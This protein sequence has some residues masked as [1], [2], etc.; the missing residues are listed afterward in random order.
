MH[1]PLLAFVR[2][3]FISKNQYAFLHKQKSVR[4]GDKIGLKCNHM[5]S[6]HKSICYSYGR[7]KGKGYFYLL[8]GVMK[9]VVNNIIYKLQVNNSLNWKSDKKNNLGQNVTGI[10]N[11]SQ[12]IFQSMVCEQKEILEYRQKDGLIRGQFECERTCCVFCTRLTNNNREFPLSN[13]TWAELEI[14]WRGCDVGCCVT[15]WVKWH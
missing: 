2:H 11:L 7:N 10:K 15:Y 6:S 12:K 9:R 14:M 1:H 3:F 5:G 4:F 8:E 13:L